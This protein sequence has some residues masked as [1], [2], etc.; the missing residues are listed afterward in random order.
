MGEYTND[1]GQTVPAVIKG[2]FHTIKFHTNREK[3]PGKVLQ[4]GQQNR[5][6]CT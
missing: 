1:G 4:A 6:D 5:A 3:P 2:K